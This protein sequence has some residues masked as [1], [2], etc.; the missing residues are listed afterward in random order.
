MTSGLLLSLPVV[1]LQRSRNVKCQLC[2]KAISVEVGAYNLRSHPHATSG[3]DTW[4]LP[5]A[6]PLYVSSCS[7]QLPWPASFPLK[8]RKSAVRIKEE[9]E[10]DD[11]DLAVKG[12]QS[13]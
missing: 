5:H 8:E 3:Q 7:R 6:E 9:R 11:A 12:N 10:K 2:S 4:Q 13:S 1:T